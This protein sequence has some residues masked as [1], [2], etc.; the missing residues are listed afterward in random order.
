MEPLSALS[1]A[2]SVVQ[3][4]DFA[5]TLISGT[6]EISKSRFGESEKNTDLRAITESLCGLN[7][8]LRGSLN[9]PKVTHF[10]SQDREIEKLC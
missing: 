4:L 9:R 7:D 5:G 2:T 8:E 10:S 3:F 1:I 6:W